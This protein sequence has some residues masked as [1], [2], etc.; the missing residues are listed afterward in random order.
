MQ[1]IS[2][3]QFSVP[4][5]IQFETDSAYKLG[6]YISQF[7]GRVLLLNIRSENK[8]SE[9]LLILKNGLSK[10]SA[11]VILY[12][13]LDAEPNSDQIDSVTYFAKKAHIDMI[14]A[15]GSLDTYAAAKAVAILAT[16]SV[17]ATDLLNGRAKLKNPALPLIVVPVEPSMGEELTPSFTMVDSS[18]GMRKY[19]E[20]ESLFPVASFYDPKIANHLTSDTAARVGGGALVYAIESQL[21]P[22]SNQLSGTMALRAIDLIKKNLTGLYKEPHNEKL[23]SNILWAC[24]MTGISSI[25]SPLGVT[26]AISNALRTY[27]KMNYYDAL[28]LILP[29]VMEYYL[30]AAPAQYINIAR[31]LGEDVKDISVIEAAIK[32]V[33]GVRRLF[34]EINLPTRLSEFEIRKNLLADIAKGATMFTQLE[35][36]P[37]TLTRNEIESILLAAY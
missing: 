18:D 33:E 25:S 14:V 16:N 31:S 32:A 29:H 11:G 10:H 21:C 23:I 36:A 19:F 8:N 37:R 13:D 12:D 4:T 24:I 1:G 26:Y 28:A 3:A 5:R 6:G 7:G 2:W 35:N 22:K 27:A 20:H 30:T 9:E 34:L 15:Y 17:F